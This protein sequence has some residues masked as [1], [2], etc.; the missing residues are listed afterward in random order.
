MRYPVSILFALVTAVTTVSLPRAQP[1]LEGTTHGI[2]DSVRD[3]LVGTLLGG[4]ADALEHAV[5][6]SEEIV[7]RLDD[8]QALI[9]VQNTLEHFEPG[10]RV[11]LSPS[12]FGTRL[13]HAPR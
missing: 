6:L 12:K 1:T 9:I 8:G 4:Y 13:E 10:E 11:L 3:V 5:G 2:I 7:V